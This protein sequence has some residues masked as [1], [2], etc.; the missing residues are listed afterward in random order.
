M[1]RQHR[2]ELLMYRWQRQPELC[3]KQCPKIRGFYS[4]YMNQDKIWEAFQND[5]SLIAV[6]FPTRRRFKFLANRVLLGSRV[7]NIGVGNGYLESLLV[8]KGADVS[9]LDPSSTAI[10]RIR[11]RL[12]LGEKAQVGYSQSLPFSDASF[13]YVIMSEVLE[14]LDNMVLEE[15][16]TEVRRVLR[17]GGQFVGT[18]PADENLQA[19]IVVCPCCGERF[20]RWGHVQSFSQERLSRLL[21]LHFENVRVR[22]MYFIDCQRLNWKGKLS[23][24][25]MAVQAVMGVKGSNQNFYF[26]AVRP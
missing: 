9:C 2:Y 11:E 15:T 1:T 19:S 16:L 5:E 7:L 3:A 24:A 21:N 17:T 6:G 25:L 12:D 26:E 23:G 22:R 4:I 10:Q 14:H 13:D 20:H 18:V 8:E